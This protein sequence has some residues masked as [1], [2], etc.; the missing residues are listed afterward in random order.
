MRDLLM[1]LG[2]FVVFCIVFSGMTGCTQS[3]TTENT[4]AVSANNSMAQA[5]GNSAPSDKKASPYPPLKPAIA[6]ADMESL[7]GTVSHVADRKG[8]VVLLNMW[9]IWCGPCRAEMPDLVA[10][11]QT[12]G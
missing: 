1:N 11:Q 10:L 12:Y 3:T 8:K 2:L 6:N 7:D 4:N 9:G 5:P